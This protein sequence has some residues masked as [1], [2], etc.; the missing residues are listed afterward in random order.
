MRLKVDGSLDLDWRKPEPVKPWHLMTPE[1]RDE[2][3]LNSILRN[4]PALTYEKVQELLDRF[5]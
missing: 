4:H 2:E 5:G 3:L 1:E